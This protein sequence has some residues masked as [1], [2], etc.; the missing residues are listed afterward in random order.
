MKGKDGARNFRK[1]LAGITGMEIELKSNKNLQ[2]PNGNFTTAGFAQ[3]Q[4]CRSIL[5]SKDAFV[6]L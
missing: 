6:L 2:K 3:I 1:A 5:Y 4:F